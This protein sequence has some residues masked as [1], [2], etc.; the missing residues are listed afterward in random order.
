MENKSDFH[1]LKGYQ[2]LEHNQITSAM[3]D[4]LEMICRLSETQSYIRVGVLADKLNVKT[5]SVSKMVQNLK[6]MRLVDFE[7]YGYIRLT[8]K[9]QEVGEY[10]IYRHNVLNRFLCYI[11]Q[12][13][14]E[15]EQVEKIEHFLNEETVR[16][17]DVLNH[18]FEESGR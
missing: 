16:N 15:I 7:K 10:L 9:G 11:N 4:Y 8:Q 1:T 12:S 6:A 14:D 17:I 2:L 18:Q 3:E 13:K 5:S